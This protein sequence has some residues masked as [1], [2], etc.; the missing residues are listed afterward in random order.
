MESKVEQK[1]Q[2]WIK[3]NVLDQ[4]LCTGC[5]ACVGL[6]PYQAYHRD[7]TVILHD[8]DRLYG[9]CEAYCPR[10]PSD[11]A[12]LNKAL[13][14]AE[15]LTPEL[16][17]IKG[18]YLTRAT[19]EKVREAAQHGGTVSALMALA[20]SE[21]LIDTAVLAEGDGS[22]ISHGASVGEAGEVLAKA[23][24]KFVVS[25][26]G[27]TFNQVSQSDAQ[28]IGVVATPCQALALAKMRV[29]PTPGDEAR[30]AKLKL[31]LG[32]FCGWALDWRGL[33]ALLAEKMGD[34]E[35]LGLDIPPSKH[36]C[37]EVHTS[38]G[39]VEIGIEQV[40]AIVRS[41]CNYCFDLTCEFS[42]LSVGSARSPEGWRVDRGWNQVIVRSAL[43]QELLDLARS[44]EVLE[45]KELPQGNLEKLK[46][47]AAN[48][49]RTCA[50]NLSEMSG[51][52]DDLIY[53]KGEDISCQ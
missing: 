44:K 2:V 16:G 39:M 48:K 29:Q 33:K 32:L 45:F 20:L 36:H 9:R 1:G 23:G 8:C 27:A 30:T 11:L 53:L 13:F 18:L 50:A 47:A 7:S 24:S 4:G 51:S 17:A 37:M 46:Q 5:T 49:K 21:G 42:D 31:V 3:Q 41:S 10:S 34:V 38:G 52:P 14:D 22:L 19:D 40:Q 43:G 26:T 15:D 12:A 25:P 28:A 35:I 6:C